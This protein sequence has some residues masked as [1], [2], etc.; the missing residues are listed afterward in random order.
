MN[1]VNEPLPPPPVPVEEPPV[2]EPVQQLSAD[3]PQ[4]V[5]I[6]AGTSESLTVKR[7][8]SRTVKLCWDIPTT[9]NA[10][11]ITGYQYSIDGGQTWTS[12]GSTNTCITITQDGVGDLPLDQF[13]IRAM[14]R[15]AE[16]TRSFVIISARLQPRIIHECPVG[17]VRSDRFGGPTQRVLLYEV[18]LKMDLQNP[19]SIY[20]PDWVAI[21]VHPD[22]GL[23]NLEGWK[24][25][26][27]V[28]HNHHREYLLTTE[29]S[30]VVD[31]GFV[32]GGFA[33]IEN[34][35]ENPFPMIGMGFTGATV[36]GFDYRLYDD[37]GRKVDF[38]IA[39]YK[40]GGIFQALKD[41]EDPRVL[42][43]VL[44]ESLDWDAATYIRSE[45]TVPVETSLGTPGYPNDIVSDDSLA[46]RITF[47][48]LMYATRGGLV[49]SQPQWIELYNNTGTAALPINLNGWQLLVEARDSEIQH[50]YSVIELQEDLYIA[51]NQTVLLVTRDRRHSGHLREGQVYNLFH[52]DSS[53]S[54]LGLRQNAMLPTSGFL[55]QL[56]APDGT[57][58]DTVGNLDGRK[59]TRDAPAWQLPSGWVEDGAR[60]S[61]LRRYEDS[62]ALVGTDAKS[63]VRAADVALPLELY[64]GHETD[65]GSPGY[66]EGGI[67][68]V[69]LSHFRARRTEAGVIVEWATVSETDNAGFNILRGERKTGSFVKVNPTLILGGGTTADKQSYIYR[70]PTAAVNIPYDYRLEEVSL[71]G[72]RH[73]VATVRLRG[74]LSA[75]GKLLWKWAD[76]KKQ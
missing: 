53:A 45:W 4:N 7:I 48:E 34:P 16:G 50:R 60:T 10:D 76:V 9:L 21:Y 44:L 30:V 68:P 32:E 17:W 55:L 35:E 42:R 56:F 52:H 39:C 22:E 67:A 25:H 13:K 65:I 36:P 47:S 75:T 73:A 43:N 70:D 63:W 28:P 61:L 6:N 72:E 51:P 15:N 40:R 20:K 5:E 66:K 24:L 2:E 59:I 3:T 18:K 64:Y 33:F 38:G 54:K 23:E 58:V 29:N 8:D 37:T 71:S 26:V 57:L 74:H 14:N 41:M 46:G 69:M 62:T 31:A 1:D 12:T 11:T 27:A 19:I 49:S